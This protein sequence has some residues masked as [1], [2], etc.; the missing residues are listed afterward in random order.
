ML[1]ITYKIMQANRVCEGKEH[2]TSSVM[3]AC[4]CVSPV[5]F[6]CEYC[7]VSHLQEAGSHLFIPLE[8]A[9]EIIKRYQI[10]DKNEDSSSKY[11]DIERDILNYIEFLKE[12]K[13]KILSFKQEVHQEIEGT[14]QSN[15][16]KIDHAINLS[17]NQLSHL[18]PINS[19]F[20]LSNIPQLSSIQ[21]I[22]PLYYTNPT[23]QSAPLHQAISTMIQL[24]HPSLYLPLHLCSFPLL[25]I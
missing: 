20:N 3:F 13:S 11:R 12:F 21:D 17:Y 24:S 6:L 8:S 14:V 15:M 23:I 10:S 7:V 25:G 9:R 22:I 18:T 1:D 4:R 2:C 5:V 19:D 16:E